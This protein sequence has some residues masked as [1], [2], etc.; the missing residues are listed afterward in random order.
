MMSTLEE[1]DEF[2]R[3]VNP[4][5][6]DC[7]QARADCQR[8]EFQVPELV[9]RCSTCGEV[10]YRLKALEFYRFMCLEPTCGNVW[11]MRRP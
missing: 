2:Q 9:P 8:W 5:F 4:A 11:T 6:E 1:D 3:E 10:A 7:L